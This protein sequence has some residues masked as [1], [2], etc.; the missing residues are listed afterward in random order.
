MVIKLNQSNSSQQHDNEI[1]WTFS[2]MLYFS[3][4][5]RFVVGF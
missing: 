5:I 1:F 2:N 4:Y 3:N